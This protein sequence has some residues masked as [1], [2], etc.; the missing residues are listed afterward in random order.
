MPISQPPAG[1]GDTVT[2]KPGSVGVPVAAS[3]AIVSRS[4][5][6]PQPFGAEGEIAIS[7]PTVMKNYLE[8]PEA[9]AKK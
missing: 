4:H 7:G 8:N 9:D 1:K 6:T 2:D 3:V 5:L